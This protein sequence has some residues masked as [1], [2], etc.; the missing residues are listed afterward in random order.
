MSLQTVYIDADMFIFY[1]D[2]R[3]DKGRIARET[4]K[5]VE[6]H[7]GTEIH[8]KVPLSVLGELLLFICKPKKSDYEPIKMIE[9]LMKYGND[10]P[11]AT[12]D[13]LNLAR[14]LM[15]D[16]TIKPTDAL[17]VAHALLDTT[18]EWLLT[19]DTRLITNLTIKSKMDEMENSFAISSEFRV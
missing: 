11:V 4:L 17:L 16:H 2:K 1:F 18:T 15:T 7:L 19:T 8:V 3:N 12:L 9:L 6:R 14:E 5:K 13:I 10:H